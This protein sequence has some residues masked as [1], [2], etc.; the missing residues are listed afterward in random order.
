MRTALAALVCIAPW[1][2]GCAPRTEGPPARAGVA[3]L[4]T[5]ITAARGR[6][7]LVVFWATWCRPCVDEIPELIALH[8]DAVHGARVLAVSLDGFLSGDERA[9][10]VVQEFL[11]HTP[12]PY[13]HRVYV[14]GQD[15]IANAFDLS[16]SIPYAILY[17]ASGRELRRFEGRTAASSVRD[18]LAASS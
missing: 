14:G 2:A 5:A 11:V 3:E 4:Q 18:V 6:P 1:L 12:T 15:D 10:A 17:D 13:P 8:T 16:G 9:L 7:L